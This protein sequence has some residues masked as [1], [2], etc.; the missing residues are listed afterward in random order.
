MNETSIDENHPEF[1][2]DKLDENHPEFHLS[3][4]NAID[5]TSIEKECDRAYT[6]TISWY[7]LLHVVNKLKDGKSS[8]LDEIPGEFI[9]HLIPVRIFFNLVIKNRKIPNGWKED[10]V[11]LLYKG[12]GDKQKLDNF[13]GI[14]IG[15]NIGKCFTTIIYNRL[16]KEVEKRDLLGQIQNAFRKGKRGSDCIW[17]QTQII[18]SRKVLKKKFFIAFIDLR[19][20]LDR[21]Y[22]VG[23]WECIHVYI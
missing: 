8:G 17:M 13:R 23:L 15:S 3:K 9:K 22:R 12:K 2:L 16:E 5:N 10:K 11:I 18:E 21:V 1:R 6:K 14:S 20:A 19:K 7:E 4:L